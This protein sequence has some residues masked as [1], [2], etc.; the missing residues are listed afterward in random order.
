MARTCL[1]R[2]ISTCCLASSV[3][4]GRC[5]TW[6]KSLS[7]PRRNSLPL[8]SEWI[9]PAD[10]FFRRSAWWRSSRLKCFRKTGRSLGSASA[11][12][13]R[14]FRMSSMTLW[15]LTLKWLFMTVYP[16]I[17]NLSRRKWP[18]VHQLDHVEKANDAYRGTNAGRS[19][20]YWAL[21]VFKMHACKTW[22]HC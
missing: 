22:G 11:S 6:E 17:S 4:M 14:L 1:V 20:W 18:G 5:T 13:H 10:L 21:W 3:S 9:H 8:P 16:S 12:W 2:W 7:R 19:R 15:E